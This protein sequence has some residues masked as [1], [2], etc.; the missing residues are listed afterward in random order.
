M[1]DSFQIHSLIIIGK[2]PDTRQ[3]IQLQD[4]TNNAPAE[5]IS[6]IGNN[7]TGKSSLLSDI[8]NHFQAS[9]KNRETNIDTSKATKLITS[10]LSIAGERFHRVSIHAGSNT[11]ALKTFVDSEAIQNSLERLHTTESPFNDLL[12]SLLE[13][14]HPAVTDDRELA[15]ALYFPD[16]GAS[17]ICLMT[18]LERHF[19]SRRDQFLLY[20]GEKT[21]QEKTVFEAIAEFRDDTPNPLERLADLWNGALEKTAGITFHTNTA[22]FSYLKDSAVVELNSLSRA[23]QQFLTRTG[24]IF[25]TLLDKGKKPSLIL[26]DEPEG[27]LSTGLA[28]SFITIIQELSKDQ[29]LQLIV[30]TKNPD[31]AAISPTQFIFELAL[32]HEGTRIINSEPELPH[33][34]ATNASN[35]LESPPAKKVNL[36]KLTRAIEATDDQD[37]LA[38]LVDEL[39]SLRK[40]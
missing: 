25:L 28:D 26:I 39:M 19:S 1:S 34:E 10:S 21:T 38:N 18:E 20:L 31:I 35:E 4:E 30:A 23:L 37:E 15:E 17:G 12:D 22:T 24:V 2:K 27:G 29:N 36:A 32:S 7:G 13:K 40:L 11:L 6:L 5:K 33:K 16:D 3:F 9:R 8:Q 14:E